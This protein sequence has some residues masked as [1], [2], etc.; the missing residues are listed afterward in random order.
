MRHAFPLLLSLLL[1]SLWLA[2]GNAPAAEEARLLRMPAVSA[3]Q[4]AFEYGGDIWIADRDGGSARRLTT[5]PGT[6]TDPRFS[7]DGSLLA[8]TGQYDG[9]VDVYVVDVAGG[10][11]RRLTWHPGRDQ[12]RGWTT[13]SRNVLFAS[14]RTGAPYPDPRL[15]TVALDG[16]LPTAL[17]LHRAWRG[18]YSPDGRQLVYEMAQPWEVE[19]RNYRGGQARPLWITDLQS[20][21]TREIPGAGANNLCPVWLGGTIYF[22]SDR[23]LAMNVWAYDVSTGAV[24]QITHFKE[25]DC[26]NMSGGGG[27]LIFENG[28]FLYTL[29]AADKLDKLV[30]TLEG[31]FPWARPHWVA[32]SEDIREMAISP[33]GKRAVFE[34][35]GDIYTVPAEK[36]DVRNLTNSPGAADRTPS[37]SPDGQTI[38]WFCDESG[39]YALVLADQT[40]GHRR[41]IALAGPTFFYTPSWS[42]DSKYLAF[43]DAD[44]VLWVVDVD[45][46]KAESVDCEGSAHPRRLIYPEWSTG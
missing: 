27:R 38:A 39:E 34:A 28:G 12:V 15:W 3:G 9:N 42:P 2:A 45:S 7:P 41:T 33:S 11:P 46:G 44:R 18:S 24:D 25:F 43:T 17:P 40:G 22:L 31:D 1:S 6:E 37:W 4:V 21:D 29:D 23:D 13:D 32:T 20:L 30:V 10:E 26:K 35:R 36:G 16:G 14:G 19:F 5:F 8:F